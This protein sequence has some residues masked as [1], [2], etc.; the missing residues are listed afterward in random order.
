MLEQDVMDAEYI[1]FTVQTE[2]FGIANYI[3]T[4]EV[5]VEE[6]EK[7]MEAI[8]AIDAEKADLDRSTWVRFIEL[9]RKDVFSIELMVCT[10]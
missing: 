8:C 6:I 10:K 9:Y 2:D 4:M 5:W 1:G 7:N 3:R